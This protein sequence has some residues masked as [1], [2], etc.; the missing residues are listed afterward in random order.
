MPG[1]RKLWVVRLHP[2]DASSKVWSQNGWYI[3]LPSI[4]RTEVMTQ[5]MKQKKTEG[6]KKE[7][8]EQQ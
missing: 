7:H 4:P 1:V 3:H 8:S 6:E 2:R 5:N